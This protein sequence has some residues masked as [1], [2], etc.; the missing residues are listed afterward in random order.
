LQSF[1][2]LPTS[3]GSTLRELEIEELNKKLEQIITQLKA[4]ADRYDIDLAV[5]P[6][7]I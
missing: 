7:E 5:Q 3:E 1:A 4:I 6:G 2:D